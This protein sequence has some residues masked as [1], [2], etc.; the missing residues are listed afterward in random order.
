[1]RGS[2]CPSQLGIISKEELGKASPG[3][4][5]SQRLKSLVSC[6]LSAV[7]L[8]AWFTAPGK[9]AGLVSACKEQSRYIMA[10]GL[11]WVGVFGGQMTGERKVGE[12]T[13]LSASAELAQI[14]HPARGTDHRGSEE[15]LWGPQ[16]K[17]SCGISVGRSFLKERSL[18]SAVLPIWL[19]ATGPPPEVSGDLVWSPPAAGTWRPQHRQHLGA[20]DNP[21]NR[22]PLR[23]LAQNPPPSPV[24]ERCVAG[25]HPDHHPRGGDQCPHLHRAHGFPLPGLARWRDQHSQ[26][27]EPGPPRPAVCRR[28]PPRRAGSPGF[29][30]RRGL[31]TA[32]GRN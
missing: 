27:C 28:P 29:L 32:N 7:E 30:Q 23:C 11:Y 21:T 10:F 12:S 25:G 5:T 15:G 31:G 9:G 16:K 13:Y 8:R 1:M 14:S 18:Q 22:N 19:P 6:I 20:G 3:T 26:R 4:T 2:G 24:P 17:G